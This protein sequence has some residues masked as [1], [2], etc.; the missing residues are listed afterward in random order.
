MRCAL[1]GCG[2]GEA[3]YRQ[4]WISFN[5]AKIYP[6]LYFCCAN[7]PFFSYTNI[8]WIHRGI[9]H[10]EMK[11]LFALSSLAIGLAA[12]ADGSAQAFDPSSLSLREVGARNTLVSL[13]TIVPQR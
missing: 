10:P 5:D 1:Q 6:G 12:A 8:D 4:A 11:S 3:I 2:D 7:L 9:T 13:F